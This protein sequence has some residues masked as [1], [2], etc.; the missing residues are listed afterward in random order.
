ML[1]Q[2]RG[3]VGGR[4]EHTGK[5]LFVRAD[6]GVGGI[7]HIEVHRAV[8]GID[9]HLHRVPDVID[10][11]VRRRVRVTVGSGICVRYPVKLAVGDHHVR[12]AVEGEERRG[13]GQTRLDVVVE[14]HPAVARDRRGGE[15]LDIPEAYGE[16]EPVQGRTDGDAAAAGVLGVDITVGTGIVEFLVV[17]LHEHVIGAGA[18]VIDAGFGDGERRRRR[19]QGDVLNE[20][21]RRPSRGYLVDRRGRDPI[22]VRVGD[23]LVH[24]GLRLGRQTRDAQ[25]ARSEHGLGQNVVHQIPVDA[26]AVEG[27]VRPKLLELAVTGDEHLRIP[28]ADVAYGHAV[29]LKLGGREIA[30]E[31]I[32]GLADGGKAVRRAG[33]G[34]VAGD[35]GRFLRELVRIHGQPL[36][37]R[38]H[39]G[40]EDDQGG[41]PGTDGYGRPELPP[42]THCVI[43][44]RGADEKGEGHENADEGQAHVNV[45][46]TRAEDR[47]RGGVE[48]VP[49]LEQVARAGDDKERP[50]Q[51]RDVG[52]RAAVD[53]HPDQLPGVACHLGRLRPAGARIA[54]LR[55]ARGT[56]VHLYA[57]EEDARDDRHYKHGDQRDE[58]EGVHI[59]P[60]RQDEDVERQVVME[61]GI[62]GTERNGVERP[63][64][65]QPSARS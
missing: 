13:R 55:L 12:V 35:V 29:R 39:D 6:D 20:K 9:D 26:D 48:Q 56:L 30:L 10:S 57:P 64:E 11:A 31:R 23:V 40:Q 62:S 42:S 32:R 34:D 43:D 17:G 28:E 4:L 36:I 65:H 60:G 53:A 5:D 25:L 19:H 15:E 22:S 49:R 63:G 16:R 7:E 54:R 41:D 33:G 3:H 8:V 52:D 38:R 14:D 45:G 51:R 47:A 61:D 50:E 44:K 1:A 59:L 37:C 58:Q 18:P 2:A 21:V 27:V 24:P 46:V